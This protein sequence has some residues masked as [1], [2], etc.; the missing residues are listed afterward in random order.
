MEFRKGFRKIKFVKSAILFEG[1]G[2]KFYSGVQTTLKATKTKLNC[3]HSD[4][5]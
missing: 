5:G 1:L 4:C 3:D 2:V